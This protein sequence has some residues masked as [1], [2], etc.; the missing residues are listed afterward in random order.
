[1]L[2]EITMH[3]SNSANISPTD[4]YKRKNLHENEC[5]SMTFS[6]KDVTRSP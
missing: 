3:Y 4:V 1:M 6:G 2:N 5:V